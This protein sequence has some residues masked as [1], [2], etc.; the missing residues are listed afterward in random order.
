MGIEFAYDKKEECLKV[1]KESLS[2]FDE[3]LIK[4]NDQ[5]TIYEESVDKIG[6]GGEIYPKLEVGNLFFLYGRIKDRIFYLGKEYVSLEDTPF[7]EEPIEKIEQKE[8]AIVSTVTSTTE[9]EKEETPSEAE[10]ASEKSPISVSYVKEEF[11]YEEKIKEA[12]EEKKK[13]KG[14]RVENAKQKLSIER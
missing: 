8:P 3:V 5:D 10:P 2:L 13:K 7:H 4:E 6:A 9:N 1:N 11:P 14:A 12:L